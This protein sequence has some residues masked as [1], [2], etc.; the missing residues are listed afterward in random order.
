MRAYARP[1][2]PQQAR[3]RELVDE[4]SAVNG[5][6]QAIVNGRIA[7]LNELLKNTPHVLVGGRTIM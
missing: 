7:R 6:L 4:T 2:D 1:T 3:R 5:E